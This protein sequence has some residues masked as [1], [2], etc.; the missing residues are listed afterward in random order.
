MLSLLGL[1]L[2]LVIYLMQSWSFTATVVEQLV[3]LQ[4]FTFLPK[5]DVNALY[6]SAKNQVT[7]AGK[8]GFRLRGGGGGGVITS[9]QNWGGGGVGQ[10]A[11]LTGPSVAVDHQLL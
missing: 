11:Q 5:S 9:P 4:M 6:E 8:S 10:R 1:T 2:M 3:T 7:V